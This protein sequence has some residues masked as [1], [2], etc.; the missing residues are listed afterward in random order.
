MK[1]EPVPALL[2]RL[3]LMMFLQYAIWGA[4]LPILFPFLAG[5]RHFTNDQIG[6][7]FAVGALGAIVAPFIAGQVADRWFATQKFLGVLHLGGAVLMWQLASLT[8]FESFLWFSLAY[9]LLYCPTMPLTNSL[10]FHH[11]P[12]ANAQ[13]GKVRLWGTIGWIVVGIAMGQWLLHHHTPEGTKEVIEAAQNAGRADAF[14]LA[15]VLGA[16]M[17]VYCFLLPNTPPQ[18]GKKQ[19]AI[20]EAFESVSKNPLLTLFLLTIPIA[21]IHQFYFV[22]TSGFLSAFQ[23]DAAAAI[24]Q[25]FGVGGGGLMTIGQM[26][27][28]LVLAAVPIVARRT[29]RKSILVV[30]TVAYA[31]RMALF[32]YV[33]ELPLPPILTLVLG[34]A[35]HGV[36]F[37]CFIF[38]AF[39]IIDEEAPKDVRA[40]TQSL[41]NLVIVGLGIIVGSKVSTSIATWAQHGADKLDYANADQTRDLFSMPMWAALVVLVLLLKF[42]PGGAPQRA[43]EAF[44][45]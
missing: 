39:M 22:H 26:T 27:E 11:L 15:S 40:S 25:V 43:P 33:H 14:K 41:Y 6:W 37:G 16:L 30:G 8:T 35:L 38:L 13:F 7:M 3:S 44:P 36:C 10:A 5:H 2:P 28:I 18:L 29:S 31:V 17:G 32:A 45:S 42:Y 24:N 20:A 21:C 12:D 9:S 4:W 34:V 1:N 19:V 23:S